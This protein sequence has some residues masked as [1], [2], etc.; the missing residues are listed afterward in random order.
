MGGYPGKEIAYGGDTA[1]RERFVLDYLPLIKKIAGRLGI[2]LPS[3]MDEND[4]IGSGIIGLLEALERYDPSR[5]VDFATFA[6]LRIKGAMVDELRKLSWAP[7][8]FFSQ[9]R[10]VQG[11]GEK[12]AQEQKREADAE[13]IAE[14]LGWKPEDVE[15]VWLH[16]NLLSVVSLEK[17]LFA[18]GEDDGVK[19][20]DLISSAEEGPSESADRNEM[21]LELT[22][23]I[24]KL[25]EREQMLLSLYYYEELTQKEIAKVL[26]ISTVRV[27]QIHARAIQRLQDLLKES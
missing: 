9:L 2:A 8:S 23:A 15:Q 18:E 11:A 17:V 16:Y 1:E 4:L 24:K 25:P 13:E 10:Q 14:E 21:L 12:V 19:L 22:E 7:R 3:S 20:E 6:S 27:S 26:Q 5:G